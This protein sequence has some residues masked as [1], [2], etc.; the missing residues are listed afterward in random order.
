MEALIWQWNKN[1]ELMLIDDRHLRVR[2]DCGMMLCE[3]YDKNSRCKLD[4]IGLVPDHNPDNTKARGFCGYYKYRSSN[5]KANK[6][7]KE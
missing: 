2:L 1:I 6:G 4:R 3:N 7:V 5:Q